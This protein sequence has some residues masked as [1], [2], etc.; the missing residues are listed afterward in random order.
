VS[1][2]RTFFRR[3]PYCGRRFEIR[4]EGKKLIAEKSV[5]SRV[6]IMEKMASDNLIGGA[7]LTT[8]TPIL[9]AE[10]APIT[11]DVEEFEYAYR[12]KHCGHEWFERREE[13]HRE[14]TKSTE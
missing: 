3:C 4:L 8:P 10:G 5:T 1:E 9:V 2:L 12:C 13:T 6:P 11:V 7:P 14:A